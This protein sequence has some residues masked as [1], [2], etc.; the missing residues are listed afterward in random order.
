MI[1]KV[2]DLIA[3]IY[4]NRAKH[5]AVFELALEGYHSEMLKKLERWTD[6]IRR[7]KT[8]TEYVSLP[9]PRDHTKEYDKVLKMLEMTTDTHIEMSDSDFAQ[10]VMDD[11]SWKR[12]FI[13]TAS[14]YTSVD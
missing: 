12:E 14:N 4:A 9:I 5:R 8:H 6:E 13:G 10:Y 7:G 3:E 1:F 11:W 2:D